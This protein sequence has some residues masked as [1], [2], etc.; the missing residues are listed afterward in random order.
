MRRR[1]VWTAPTTLLLSALLLSGASGCGSASTP[2]VP[3]RDASLAARSPGAQTGSGGGYSLRDGDEDSDDE[4]PPL[5]F[6]NDDPPLI[7]KFGGRAGPALSRRI[8][9]L[10]RRYYAVSLAGDGASACALLA[11]GLR[12]GVE[13]EYGTG[14]AGQEGC[15]APM[16]RLLAEQHSQLQADEIQS[17]L[18]TAVHV[19][20]DLGLAV[21]EFKRT[22][23]SEIAVQREG[24]AWKVDAP[25]GTYMP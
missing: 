25:A 15:A 17:M 1:A 3:K 12:P 20:G 9:A 8:A 2:P 7:G 13:T 4:H 14:Q 21:L 5:R 11:P 6:G 16:A 24:S 23:E 10:V 19:N 18:V 22:P